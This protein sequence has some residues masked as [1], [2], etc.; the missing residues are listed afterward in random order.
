MSDDAKDFLD[1][2]TEEGKEITVNIKIED[3]EKAADLM[4]TMH[5][6]NINYFGVSVQS[7]GF[8]DIKKAQELRIKAMSDEVA[9]HQEAMF[10]LVNKRDQQYLEE[11]E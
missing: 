4:D 8:W 9:R 10:N 11:A 1:A 7:W 6:R 5:N 2:L 3:P